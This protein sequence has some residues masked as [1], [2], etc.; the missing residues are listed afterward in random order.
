MSAK[1][2]RWPL[3]VIALA[4]L[5]LG[6]GLAELF[7]L[8]FARGDVYPAYSS[9]RSDP[10]GT[11]AM[12]EALRSAGIETA[13]NLT[14][15][16]HASLPDATLYWCGASWEKLDDLGG[17]PAEQL[18]AWIARGGRLVLTFV[19]VEGARKDRR[20]VPAAPLRT[21]KQEKSPEPESEA[22]D[23]KNPASP[24]AQEH[25][26]EP[27]VSLV[28]K[29]AVQRELLQAAALE[30]AP[31]ARA[32]AATPASLPAELPWHTALAF[33]PADAAW[34]RI[35]ELNGTPVVLERAFGAGTVVLM[36]D[37]YWHSNEAVFRDRQPALLAWLQG[38]PRRAVFEE[39][40]LGV[41]EN[42]S[43]AIL[44]R[45]YGLGHTALVLAALLLVFVWHNATSL[46]PASET[47]AAAS[48]A[49][50]EAAGR[51]S[52][53][54]FVNLLR[55]TLPPAEL[56]AACLAEFRRGP[57]WRRVNASAQTALAALSD[58]AAARDPVAANR[59][60]HRL[61]ARKF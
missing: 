30:R 25:T 48:P 54:G 45:R 20:A 60:A 6:Y 58:R 12:F 28:T 9:L 27:A 23:P 10:L 3:L 4:L 56:F 36:S 44:A 55:R 32:T 31:V 19:P 38:A 21:T 1:H 47:G 43:V 46:V 51:D 15:I 40:H 11:Q 22:G 16:D 35:Y 7:R 13:R 37:A 2:P 34:T 49:E 61:L 39:S 42:S 24:P 50:R 18:L 29:L 59:E 14:A 52:A 8:R 17:K 5:V 41:V 26:P 53:A 33:A 57:A